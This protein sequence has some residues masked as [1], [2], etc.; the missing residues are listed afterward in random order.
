MVTPYAPNA[1][2][3]VA[4]PSENLTE[5]D[6]LLS[7]IAPKFEPKYNAELD[8]P[9]SEGAGATVWTPKTDTDTAT[10]KEAEPVQHSRM[11]ESDGESEVHT[12]VAAREEV[13][14]E[15]AENASLRSEL[16]T[17]EVAEASSPPDVVPKAPA[18]IS[19]EPREEEVIEDAQVEDDDIFGGESSDSSHPVD[20]D[21]TDVSAPPIEDG[22][23]LEP[24][25]VSVLVDGSNIS[26][27]ADVLL[28]KA[29]ED[30]NVT[31][32]TG[33]VT[34]EASLHTL[35]RVTSIS[36]IDDEIVAVDAQV[37]M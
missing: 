2:E 6:N 13:A 8:K 29:V 21:T 19:E 30:F 18:T 14:T 12:E 37:C 7:Q 3:I 24:A 36:P 17:S 10:Q 27:T 5:N 20:S 34:H 16:D 26:V 4:D 9:A 33:L 1:F 22:P 23:A 11:V 15:R 35:E 31:T 25:T 28:V 32:T